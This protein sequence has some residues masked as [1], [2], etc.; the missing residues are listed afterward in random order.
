MPNRTSYLE[1]LNS[2]VFRV[3]LCFYFYASK[4]FLYL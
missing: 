3:C 4:K 1:A 2:E